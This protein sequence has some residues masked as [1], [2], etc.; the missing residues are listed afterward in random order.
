M[1]AQLQG[2]EAGLGEALGGLGHG[3]GIAQHAGG[4]VGAH[5]VAAPAEQAPHRLAGD[6]AGEVPEREV[7]GPAAAV[8]ELDVRQHLVV[9]L[10]T[11]RVLADEEILVAGKAEHEVAG[12][13]ADAPLVVGHAPPGAV[14]DRKSTRLTSR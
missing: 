6:L 5:A 1:E 3:P 12:A 7:E 14:A 9:A 13:N 8:V 10:D 11:A 4:G 2:A